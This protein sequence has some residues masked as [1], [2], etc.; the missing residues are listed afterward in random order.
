M[1]KCYCL[2]LFIYLCFK[3]GNEMGGKIHSC[4]I[5]KG[6]GSCVIQP[7]T[8]KGKIKEGKKHQCVW[9]C[10]RARTWPQYWTK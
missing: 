6:S 3:I 5:L 9:T 7:I 8:F 2:I 4:V 10:G 1:K